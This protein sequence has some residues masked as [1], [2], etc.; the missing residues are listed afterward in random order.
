MFDNGFDFLVVRS[1]VFRQTQHRRQ[2]VIGF[3]L[4]PDDHEQHQQVHAVRGHEQI[5]FGG[6]AQFLERMNTKKHRQLYMLGKF[7]R[8]FILLEKKVNIEFN[9]TLKESMYTLYSGNDITHV[10]LRSLKKQK[11]K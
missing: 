9:D 3:G 8:Y 11:Q 6:I 2:L 5:A 10:M 7:Y 1:F 4:G